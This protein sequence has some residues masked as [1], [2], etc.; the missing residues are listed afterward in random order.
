MDFKSSIHMIP[1]AANAAIQ[2]LARN[3]ATA[4]AAFAKVAGETTEVEVEQE[5]AVAQKLQNIQDKLDCPH[6][7]GKEKPTIIDLFPDLDGG[8][9]AQT[10][11]YPEN[12]EPLPEGIT[13]QTLRYP[14]NGE[15]LP[16]NP[17][18][19]QTLAYPENGEPLPKKG[20]GIPK[21][22]LAFPESGEPWPKQKLP[23]PGQTLRHPE[24]G[25]DLGKP[26]KP[27]PGSPNR[28]MATHEGG[29]ATPRLKPWFEPPM[30]RTHA[31]HEAGDAPT[32][33]NPPMG[34]TLAF[35]ESGDDRPFKPVKP[36]ISPPCKCVPDI[37]DV[38]PGQKIPDNFV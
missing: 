38:F 35:P 11:A 26:F 15:P 37:E 8:M 13:A 3:A 20:G 18:G 25:D 6:P 1:E 5:D 24:G 29:D 9:H 23:F 22:T 2:S 17:I 4:G 33:L 27:F 31:M 36:L 28:T 34:Q 19:A 32:R 10:L 21:Q 14:E 7:T 12:G 16:K 30:Q